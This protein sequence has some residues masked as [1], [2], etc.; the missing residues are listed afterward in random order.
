[1]LPKA[2]RGQ[3]ST[4]RGELL[5]LPQAGIGSIAGSGRRIAALFADW[6]MSG[7]VAMLL[8]GGLLAQHLSTAVLA[9]WV[10]VGVLSVTAFGFTPGQYLLG[11]RVVRVDSPERVGFWRAF[12]RNLLIVFVLPPLIGD[13]DGRGMHDR[14]TTTALVIA[15]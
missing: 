1:A 7:G 11:I 12:V 13:S 5:G 10:I 6:L 14:V 4:Y 2:Q 8:V 9:I 15:R 3:S